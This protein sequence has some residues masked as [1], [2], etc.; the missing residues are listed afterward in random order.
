M[1]LDEAPERLRTLPSWLLA[2]AALHA[3]REVASALT[4]VDGHR[5]EFAALACL[6]EQGPISQVEL[7]GRIGLDRSDVVRLVD[8]LADAGCVVREPDPADRRRNLLTLTADGRR[9]L[10]ELDERIRGAQ[11]ETLSALT[12]AEREQLVSLLRSVLGDG[13]S[14]RR[15]V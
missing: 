4:G 9:R 12:D 15:A 2:Q 14:P 1:N 3:R 8:R 10:D 5:S 6:D 7:A 13:G 11:A